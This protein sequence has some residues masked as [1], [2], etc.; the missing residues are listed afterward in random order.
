M[1]IEEAV[2]SPRIHYQGLPNVVLTETNALDSSSLVDL[3]E[4]GYKVIP[5]LPWGAAESI[6]IDPQTNKKSS[7][8]DFRKSTGKA[9][10]E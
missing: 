5:F 8:H 10:T 9:V 7:I 6:Y 2:S 3:Y 4:K 1:I